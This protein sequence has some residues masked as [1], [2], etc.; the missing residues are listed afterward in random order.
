[1]L[2]QKNAMFINVNVNVNVKVNVKV[3]SII[4]VIQ[5]KNMKLQFYAIPLP[6]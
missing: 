2:L 6:V 4:N 3:T 1:M 5:E